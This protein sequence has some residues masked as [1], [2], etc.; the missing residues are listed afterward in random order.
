LGATARKLISEGLTITLLALLGVSIV[1]HC[2]VPADVLPG[3]SSI[4]EIN[5]LSIDNI[6]IFLR[7]IAFFIFYIYL[8]T[9]ICLLS[10][11]KIVIVKFKA[12]GGNKQMMV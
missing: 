6:M 1:V 3:N 11:T 2:I 9:T 7:A 12:D 5:M 10:L 8:L 4:I